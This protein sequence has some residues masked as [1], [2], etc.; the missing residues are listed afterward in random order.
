MS[1]FQFLFVYLCTV[2]QL[3]SYTAFFFD[4]FTLYTYNPFQVE[5]TKRIRFSNASLRLVFFRH[6][7]SCSE[8]GKNGNY[9]ITQ[10]KQKK[11]EE[12][13]LCSTYYLHIV[14][15]PS[16]CR[17]NVETANLEC[18]TYITVCNV[19]FQKDYIYFCGLDYD[20]A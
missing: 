17:N 7:F 14:S 16:Q 1:A 15:S 13:K 8:E 2:G 12:G 19:S 10:I 5:L 11:K 18:C 6:L 20:R 9:M 3:G 4:L